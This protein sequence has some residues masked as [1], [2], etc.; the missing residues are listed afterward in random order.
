MER[1]ERILILIAVAGA[2]A[3]TPAS[4]QN[5][6]AVDLSGTWTGYTLLGDGIRAEFDLVLEKVEGGYAGKITGGTGMVP[7]MTIKDVTFKDL[8]LEFSVDFPDASG[9][10]LIKIGL[11]YENDTLKGVWANPGGD[12]NIIELQRKK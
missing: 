4:A 10:V 1:T 11:K 3:L 2:L 9:L 12:S 7:E 8:L 6:P 5:A